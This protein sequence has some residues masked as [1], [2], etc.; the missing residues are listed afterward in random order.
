MDRPYLEEGLVEFGHFPL[1]DWSNK[2]LAARYA[3]TQD[4]EYARGKP[5]CQKNHELHGRAPWTALPTCQRKLDERVI[6]FEW[7]RC[8]GWHFT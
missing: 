1:A 3:A 6:D 2:A 7:S 4:D 8:I 5:S